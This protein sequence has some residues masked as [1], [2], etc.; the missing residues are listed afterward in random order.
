VYCIHKE[1]KATIY[2]K[3][4]ERKTVSACFCGNRTVERRDDRYLVNVNSL[5]LQIIEGEILLVVMMP[6]EH[7]ARAVT[8]LSQDAA[9]KVP[10]HRVRHSRHIRDAT[11]A[12]RRIHSLILMFFSKRQMLHN[13]HSTTSLKVLIIIVS[14]T[15]ANPDEMMRSS[16]WF[17]DGTFKTAPPMLACPGLHG[18]F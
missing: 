6:Q 10:Q 7:A 1:Y 2:W 17:I 9:A 11:P 18:T 14:A 5:R 16:H 8:K 13:S 3:C 12:N 15:E 4:T